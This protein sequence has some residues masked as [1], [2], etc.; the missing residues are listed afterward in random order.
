MPSLAGAGSVQF[1]LPARPLRR[2]LSTYYFLDTG[3]NG[4]EQ[5]DFIYPE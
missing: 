4:P 2:Y 1:I 3:T 5:E